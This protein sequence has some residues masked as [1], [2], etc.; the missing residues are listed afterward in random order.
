MTP[1]AVTL[2]IAA[3]LSGAVTAVFIMLAAGIRAGDRTRCLT[4]APRRH[5]E[6][7]AR[8]VLGAGVRTGHFSGNRDGGKD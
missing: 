1:A 2:V 7:L 5:L 4:A 8:A 6:A 3:F